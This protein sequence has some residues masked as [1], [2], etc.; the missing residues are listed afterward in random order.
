MKVYEDFWAKEMEYEPSMSVLA[1]CFYQPK[2][3]IKIHQRKP[4]DQALPIKPIGD[5][6][7]S[8]MNAELGFRCAFH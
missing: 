3:S 8:A 7:Y 2:R 4:Q 1:K 6:K 5:C